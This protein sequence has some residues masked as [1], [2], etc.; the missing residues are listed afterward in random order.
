MIVA[1][2]IVHYSALLCTIFRSYV[3]I[4]PE[5]SSQR[6]PM[7]R[8]THSFKRFWWCERT[9]H[10][11]ERFQLSWWWWRACENARSSLFLAR[12]SF[13]PESAA[14]TFA[15]S[16][17][18]LAG[19]R[20][21]ENTCDFFFK[22]SARHQASVDGK[23]SHALSLLRSLLLSHDDCSN[24][25]SYPIWYNDVVIPCRLASNDRSNDSSYGKLYDDACDFFPI[26]G[27]T[28]F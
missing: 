1:T 27:C 9:P 8:E 20:T 10:A 15:S 22:V 17:S 13:A 18:S 6:A 21:W 11:P 26:Y 2:T 7:A 12:H 14:W 24:D 16:S 28:D 3:T 23:K 4:S 25:S 5:L 19:A